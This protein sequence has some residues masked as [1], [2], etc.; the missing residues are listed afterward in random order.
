[1]PPKAVKKI[2]HS[3]VE[4]LFLN[5][6]N[7]VY[8]SFIE[9][10]NVIEN[11]LHLQKYWIQLT[12]ILDDADM[13]ETIV[14]TPEQIVEFSDTAELQHDTQVEKVLSREEIKAELDRLEVEY[15]T[16]A[17]TDKLLELLKENQ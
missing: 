15:N 3:A 9:D 2:L 14:G 12:K 1:M 7:E 6:I 16:R 11:N 10:K 13:V 5:Q 8:D 17:S 4:N